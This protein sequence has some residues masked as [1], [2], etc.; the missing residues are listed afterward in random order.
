MGG[1][2]PWGAV[3]TEEFS[4]KFPEKEGVER[5]FGE[6]KKKKRFR[7]HFFRPTVATQP[8]R[9]WPLPVQKKVANSYPGYGTW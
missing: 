4:R 9:T 3:A 5:N 2:W 6:K 7:E 8:P 1:E